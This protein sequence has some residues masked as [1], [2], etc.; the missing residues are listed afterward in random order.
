MQGCFGEFLKILIRAQAK[1]VK[2]ETL[3]LA[4]QFY[5]ALHEW[6]DRV[7]LSLFFMLGVMEYF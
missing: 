3:V 6:G 2:N 1:M 5:C 4:L 7:N